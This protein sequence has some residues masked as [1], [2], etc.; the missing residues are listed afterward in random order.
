MKSSKNNQKDKVEDQAAQNSSVSET[1]SD[2][3]VE[4]A[5]G[6]EQGGRATDASAMPRSSVDSLIKDHVIIS[7][8]LGLVPVPLFDVALVAGNQVAMVHEL[9]GLYGI[10][11]KKNRTKSII[12]SLISGSI[13]ATGVI[14]LSSGAKIMPG[15]GSLVGSGS[16]SII[17]GALTYAT[18]Q[19]FV[20]HFESGGTLLDFDSKKMRQNF[21]EQFRVGRNKVKENAEAAKEA[22]KEAAVETK[23]KVAQTA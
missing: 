21:K 4:S 19:V 13:P 2:V 17:S 14:A 20:K 18:G 7:M 6:A 23:E 8:A 3:E 12:I 5:A 16:V 11:F 9:S 22:A 15:V 1:N 10:P